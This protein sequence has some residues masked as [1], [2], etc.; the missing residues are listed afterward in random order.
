MM[1]YI[2]DTSPRGYKFVL[3]IMINSN[4]WYLREHNALEDI[5][6][7]YCNFMDLAI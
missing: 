6:Y 3:T 4:I 7:N 5:K 2:W 1:N